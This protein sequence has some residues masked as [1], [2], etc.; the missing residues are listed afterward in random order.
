MYYEKFMNNIYTSSGWAS[1]SS[2][3]SAQGCL[4][5]KWN[6]QPKEGGVMLES[7]KEMAGVLYRELLSVSSASTSKGQ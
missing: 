4:R 5:G 2:F 7:A 6:A 3:A 1:D